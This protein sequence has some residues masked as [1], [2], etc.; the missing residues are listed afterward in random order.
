MTLFQQYSEE[1]NSFVGEVLW[2][3]Q[4]K[5]TTSF[6][7]SF[8]LPPPGA[9]LEPT[10]GGKMKD[11]G[12]EVAKKT[13]SYSRTANSLQLRLKWPQGVFSN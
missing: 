5:K 13:I 10:R 11:P 2:F 1:S 9:N 6:P 8:I 12:N 4:A 3:K 7:G